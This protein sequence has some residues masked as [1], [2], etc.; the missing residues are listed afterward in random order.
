M[1]VDIRFRKQRVLDLFAPG[2]WATLGQK[3]RSLLQNEGKDMGPFLN[4]V[5]PFRVGGSFGFAHFFLQEGRG[6]KEFLTVSLL[7][8]FDIRES[9]SL[10]FFKT[11]KT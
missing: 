9:I 4:Y 6:P 5:S 10:W 2:F 11:V 8:Q 1:L 3:L 7:K